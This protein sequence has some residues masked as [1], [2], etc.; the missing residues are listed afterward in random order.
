MPSHRTEWFRS[1]YSGQNG[2]CVEARL[3][4][5]EINVRDSKAISSPSLVFAPTS[6]NAFLHAL[7]AKVLR[8]ADVR[9]GDGITG[10]V[11]RA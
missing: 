6:W 11:R 9:H 5:R 7:S 3:T 2:E 4:E 10:A 1:S 8:H